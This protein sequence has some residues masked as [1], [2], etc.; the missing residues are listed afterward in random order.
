MELTFTVP[1]R[2]YNIGDKVINIR[3]PMAI[4]EI[5][6]FEISIKYSKYNDEITK[7][8]NIPPEE[9]ITVWR[10]DVQILPRYHMMVNEFI[11]VSV[12]EL[13]AEV[14]KV[15]NIQAAANHELDLTQMLTLLEGKVDMDRVAKWAASR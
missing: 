13:R 2:K 3:K 15:G 9:L 14:A 4:G 10:Y 8:G 1:D 7:T 12:E 6:G 11:L 5:T